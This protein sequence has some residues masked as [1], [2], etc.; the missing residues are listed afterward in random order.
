MRAESNDGRRVAIRLGVDIGGSGIKGALVEL[1]TGQLVSER[2]RLPTPQPA[3]P[4]AVVPVVHEVVKEVGGRGRFGCT[5]PGVV[6]RGEIHSAPNMHED[7]IGCDATD[8][9]RTPRRP[10][11]VLNDADAAGLAEATVGVARGRQGVVLLLT[12]GT[13]IGSALFLDGRLVPNTELGHLEVRGKEAEERASDKV[14]E[15]K[16]L[17][18]KQWSKRVEEYLRT[19]EGLFS[20]D[21]FVISGGVS[22]HHDKFL[23]RLEVETEV[24]P[25]GL[26]NQ[27]GIVGAALQAA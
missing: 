8:M 11:S 10:V 22:K 15:D 4:D 7:W 25:A 20:P 2:V 23:S 21:L 19:L 5:F 6:R 26:L 3:T 14:R 9:L 1:E 18:W 12:F 13:G 24:V 17:S 16:D 27:A